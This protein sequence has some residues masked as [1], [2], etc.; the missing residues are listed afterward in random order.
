[1]SDLSG[2]HHHQGLSRVQCAEVH[3]SRSLH[4]WSWRH[5]V[6]CPVRRLGQGPVLEGG[7]EAG[8]RGEGR[9]VSA[10]SPVTPIR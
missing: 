2:A 10:S 7:R 8:E 5:E 9:Q 1:M 3:K 6:L 4:V